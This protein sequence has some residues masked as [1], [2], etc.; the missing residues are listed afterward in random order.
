[1]T[2][3]VI[4]V[5]VMGM[6]FRLIV[7]TVG[8]LLRGSLP[9]RIRSGVLSVVGRAPRIE[10]P[11]GLYAHE[12]NGSFTVRIR[13]QISKRVAMDHTRRLAGRVRDGLHLGFKP[14]ARVILRIRPVGRGGSR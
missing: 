12:V 9:A 11:R 3:I 13:V 14:T 1:M 10:G 5:L 8:S 4:D 2:T 6:T 7:P